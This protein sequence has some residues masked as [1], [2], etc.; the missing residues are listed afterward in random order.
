MSKRSALVIAVTLA[1]LASACGLVPFFATLTMGTDI[2]F[3]MSGAKAVAASSPES[4]SL[5]GARGTG[6]RATSEDAALIKILEDG[7]TLPLVESSHGYWSPKVAFIATGSAET[8]DDGSIYICFDQMA[9]TIDGSVQFIR[10]YPDNHY[11]IIWPIDPANFAYDSTGQVSTWSWWGMDSEPLAKGP[12]GRLYFKVSRFNMSA[13]ADDI[14]AYDPRR[15][16]E[17]PI[18]ITPENSTFSIENFVVDAK[19]HLFIQGRPGGDY[20]ASFMRYYTDGV[21]SPN[22]IYYAS[23]SGSTWV[24]GYTTDPSGNYLIMNGYNIRGMNGIIKATIVDATTVEYQLLYPN[25]CGMNTWIG[26]T[27]YYGDGWTSPTAVIKQTTQGWPTSYDW[28][29]EVTTSGVFDGAKFTAR[30]ASY[31]KP[32][33]TLAFP[34]TTPDWWKD[35]PEVPIGPPG[36]S[37]TIGTSP[38]TV[39][40]D[41]GTTLGSL[42]QQYPEEVL[43]EL[44]PANKLFKDWLAENPGFENINFD[45]IGA[46]AWASD[47]LYGLYSSA[48][49]GSSSSDAKLV[50]LVD[51]NGDPD[52][53][54]VQLGHSAEYPSQIKIQGDY[55]YYRYAI[56]DGAN[57]ETGKHSIARQNFVGGAQEELL[58]PLGKDIE[59]NNYDV[60]GDDSI[61]YFTGYDIAANAVVGGRIELDTKVYIPMESAVELSQ[62]RV[63]D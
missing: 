35:D 13:N 29:D 45:N 1:T 62:I 22:I 21:T 46:M 25:S 42:I 14:Y 43:R 20:E 19:G 26:L 55:I 33:E 18:R 49:W 2:T 27:K 54:V 11:D 50:K 15:P 61:L 7:S 10:V 38:I 4:R 52:L 56:L 44:Y 57:Q 59:I 3:D 41:G 12:D 28:L 36:S 30:I 58:A 5:P 16:T 40:V 48:W 37:V 53:R 39:A 6:A 31:F 9:S 60:S 47:G 34:T 23:T 17:A 32:G 63:I 24:R 51:R 8:D